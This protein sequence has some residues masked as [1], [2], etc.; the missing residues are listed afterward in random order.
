VE[1]EVP[2]NS[3]LAC[4]VDFKKEAVMLNLIFRSAEFFILLLRISAKFMSCWRRVAAVA[5]IL[6][7][8]I[9]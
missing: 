5:N 1:S 4:E 8:L 3:G 6:F 7:L 9:S 2:D